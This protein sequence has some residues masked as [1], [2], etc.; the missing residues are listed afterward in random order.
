M[1]NSNFVILLVICILNIY[2]CYNYYYNQIGGNC[3]QC[4]T[5]SAREHGGTMFSAGVDAPW[6]C[7]HIKQKVA[8]SDLFILAERGLAKRPC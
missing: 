1:G 3:K 7:K 5:C 8:Y 6:A 4:E 2:Y